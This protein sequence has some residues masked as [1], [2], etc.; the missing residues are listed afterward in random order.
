MINLNFEFKGERTYVH[1]SDIFNALSKI[2]RLE[3]NKGF[4]SLIAFRN[5]ARR[6][7]VV[8]FENITTKSA[9]ATGNICAGDGAVHPF[10]LFECDERV[11]GRYAFDEDALIGAADVQMEDKSISLHCD[12]SATAIECVIALTKRL[13]YLIAPEIDGKWLF[14][15][16]NLVT[17]LVAVGTVRIV[18]KSLLPGRMSLNEIWLD[19]AL[20]GTIRFIVGKP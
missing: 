15:Q 8:S 5:I 20:V 9:V 12:G 17:P 19:D 10:W 18:Q 1:G 11:V 6:Q 2:A 13:T 3:F 16:L 7:C 14:G 4:V